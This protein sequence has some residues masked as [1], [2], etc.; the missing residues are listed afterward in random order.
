[1]RNFFKPY[2]SSNIIRIMKPKRTFYDTRK[3]SAKYK[4]V[5]EH[6]EGVGGVG[7]S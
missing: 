3:K 7:T 1:M 2:I 4:I 5:V 6:P